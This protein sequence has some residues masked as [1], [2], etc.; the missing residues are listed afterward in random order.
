MCLRADPET[1]NF[2]EFEVAGE[3][4]LTEAFLSFYAV[5]EFRALALAMAESPSMAELVR[6]LFFKILKTV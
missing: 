1:T 3:W 4:N 5:A 2:S 6:F